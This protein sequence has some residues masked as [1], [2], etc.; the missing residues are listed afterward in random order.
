MVGFET[1]RT[2]FGKTNFYKGLT[3]YLVLTVKQEGIRGFYKG[4]SWALFKSGIST[5]VYFYA[6]EYL[7]NVIRL[8]RYSVDTQ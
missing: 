2:G 6:Y 4:V 5:G 1:A 3:H 7:C 8:Y